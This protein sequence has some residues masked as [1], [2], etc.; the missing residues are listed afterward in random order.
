[1]TGAQTFR[2]ALWGGRVAVL[3]LCAVGCEQKSAPPVPAQSRPGHHD[4]ALSKVKHGK[5]AVVS[6]PNPDPNGDGMTAYAVFVRAL[7]KPRVPSSCVTEAT[8]ETYCPLNA[9]IF[10]KPEAPIEVA[11][12]GFTFDADLNND[13][14]LERT[15]LFADALA[16]YY[17]RYDE[18]GARFAQL[19][20]YEVNEG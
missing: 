13:G 1:M 4:L 17:W 14:K 6:L 10:V 19:R 9:T 15:T 3:C 7:G 18:H 16:D 5:T 12:Q 20:F 2:K 8:G 11:E